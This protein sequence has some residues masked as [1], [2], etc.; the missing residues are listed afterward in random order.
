[1]SDT[2]VPGADKL[3]RHVVVTTK[4]FTA[5]LPG[6]GLHKVPV[7]AGLVTW[8]GML[9]QTQ[10]RFI[11]PPMPRDSGVVVGTLI[12]NETAQVGDV[13][14]ESEITPAVA[15]AAQKQEAVAAAIA[16]RAK[17]EKPQT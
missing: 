3:T 5:T 9:G 1:M 8:A 16:A 11:G 2:F 13:L 10:I 12:E 6:P 14:P 4:A 7:P 17:A 15:L